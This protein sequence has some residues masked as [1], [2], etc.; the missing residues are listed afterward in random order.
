MNILKK[1]LTKI[2]VVR[3]IV[4]YLNKVRITGTFNVKTLN[5]QEKSM[6]IIGYAKQYNCKTFIETG[7]YKGDTINACKD[8]FD[9]LY[10]IELSHELFTESKKRFSDISKIHIFE[11]NSGEILPKIIGEKNNIIFWLDA[12]YSEGKTAR[13]QEDSPIIKELDFI[14][15]NTDT[16]CILIDDARCFKGKSGYPKISTI[17]NLLRN[18]YKHLNLEVKNDIIRIT[19]NR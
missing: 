13:G 6:L 14:L 8:F 5:H 10:S 18:K 12:H 19:K 17:K 2:P 7:T 4:D 1:T 16:N 9:D 15:N 3:D 11:G